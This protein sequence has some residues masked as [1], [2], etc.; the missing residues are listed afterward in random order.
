MS[1]FGSNVAG[2]LVSFVI[3][4]IFGLVWYLVKNKCKHSKCAINS[5]CLK[6]EIDDIETQRDEKEP[7]IE[8]VIIKHH[9]AVQTDEPMEESSTTGV[10]LRLD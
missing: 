7:S 2:N 5:G 9:V 1:E 4:G 6:M 8:S 10:V 3:A